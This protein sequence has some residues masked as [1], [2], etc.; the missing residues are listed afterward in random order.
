MNSR[1]RCH[2]FSIGVGPIPS[3]QIEQRVSLV[4]RPSPRQVYTISSVREDFLVCGSS[5]PILGHRQMEG[6]REMGWKET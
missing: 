3:P 4:I 5:P 2:P 1:L 6:G